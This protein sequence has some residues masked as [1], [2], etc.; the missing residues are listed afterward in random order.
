MNTNTPDINHRRTSG[1]TLIE[2]LVCLAVT[3]LLLAL[4]LPAVQAAR[5]SARRVAC[6]NHLRQ[7]GLALHNYHETFRVFPPNVMTPW[8]IAVAPQLDQRSLAIT[9]EHHFDPFSSAANAELGKQSIPIFH[10][11][12]DV[13]TTIAPHDWIA[14]NYAANLELIRPNGSLDRIRDGTSQTGLAIEVASAR[15]LA[16]ITGPTLH[17]AGDRLHTDRFHLLLADG[18]VK[19]VSFKTSDVVLSAIGTPN[20]GEVV[21]QDF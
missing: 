6:K 11:P 19:L 3:S 5:E 7:I 1:F 21:P 12:S 13:V 16:Q 9:Y 15:G 18:A 4:L 17:L 8:T 10:C 14:S 2:L 20:G